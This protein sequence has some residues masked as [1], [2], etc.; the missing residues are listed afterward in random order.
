M[1]PIPT[2]TCEEQ[3]IAFLGGQDFER[4]HGLCGQRIGGTDEAENT[5]TSQSPLSL[6]VVKRLP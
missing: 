1:D 2:A 5:I 4:H 6:R 3:G